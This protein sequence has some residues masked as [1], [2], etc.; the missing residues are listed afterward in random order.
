MRTGIKGLLAVAAACT[1]FS[2]T[3]LAEEE[4]ELTEIIVSP[5]SEEEVGAVGGHGTVMLS[6]YIQDVYSNN[7]KIE[8][9]VFGRSTGNV[10]ETFEITVYRGESVTDKSEPL[11]GT[12]RDFP[13]QVGKVEASY[14]LDTTNTEKY[15]EGKYTVVCTCYYREGGTRV[16]SSR[17][18]AVFE[19]EDYRRVKDREF[20]SRLYQKV[21]GRAGDDAG[22]KDWT[23]RLFTGRTTGATTVEGFFE[24]AEFT[25]KNTSDEQYIELLYEAIFSRTAD[26]QGRQ[27]WLDV[28]GE[29]VSRKYILRQFVNSA[30]FNNLCR[31]YGIQQGDIV[32]TENR[33][34]NLQV[35]GFVGRLYRIALGRSADQAGIND[36]TG[37]LINK[38]ETPKQ[39]A[40]GFIFS[41]EVNKRQLDNT[42]FVTLLY[43]T[44]MGREPDDAGL[45]DWVGRLNKGTAKRE[46]VYNGFA[47]SAEFGKIVSSYG[48]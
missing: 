44:M 40:K 20:V 32:L 27:N 16:E 1:M 9:E 21:F 3:A 47:D 19:I 25:Q 4:L 36:W 37:R 31:D 39:V 24:S 42:E 38:K 30:E 41:A 43:R 45:Q 35:T 28:L 17:D 8:L 18:S 29:G 34:K 11:A 2:M 12:V 48:L 7:T 5:E 46:D 10:M 22:L 23:D 26:A 33:D 14:I 6:P 13:E 15:T